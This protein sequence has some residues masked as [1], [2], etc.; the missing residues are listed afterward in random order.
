[1]R[2]FGR[3][4]YTM[5]AATLAAVACL[6]WLVP[7]SYRALGFEPRLARAGTFPAF[8]AHLAT[9]AFRRRFLAGVLLLALGLAALSLAALVLRARRRSELPW[10]LLALTAVGAAFVAVVALA[11]MTA[12]ACC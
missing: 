12:G 3:V 6:P 9:L 10:P 4:Y 1:M 8:Q 5:A 2:T 7:L 11:G